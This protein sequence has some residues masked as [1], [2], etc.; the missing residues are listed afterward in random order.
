MQ[1]SLESLKHR[2]VCSDHFSDS[3]YMCAA[4]WNTTSSLNWNA[5][6][7]ILSHSNPPKVVKERK[8]TMVPILRTNCTELT[9]GHKVLLLIHLLTLTN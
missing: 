4:D 3:A 9:P 6:P 7:T 8:T 1:N 5:M 2:V